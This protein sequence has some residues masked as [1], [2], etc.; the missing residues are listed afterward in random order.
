MRHQGGKGRDDRDRI[1]LRV[2]LEQLSLHFYT[3]LYKLVAMH[4]RLIK[5]Q[6]FGRIEIRIA[7]IQAAVLQK[8]PRLNITVGHDQLYIVIL[9]CA[10][11]HMK[12]LGIHAAAYTRRSAFI[13]QCFCNPLVLAKLPERCQ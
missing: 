1:A 9:I 11:Y 4:I 6:I 10:K 7:A 2:D 3:L 13:V 8:F 12:L 5:D